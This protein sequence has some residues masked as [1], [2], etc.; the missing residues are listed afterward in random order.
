MVKRIPRFHPAEHPLRS[1]R[2][3]KNLRLEDLAEMAGT[4]KSHLSRIEAGMTQ[5]AIDLLRRLVRA[6]GNEV[7]V[8]D[9][10]WWAPRRRNNRVEDTP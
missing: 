8:E 9:I 3:D 1:W 5:P 10:V 2:R 7:P 4:T 6:T